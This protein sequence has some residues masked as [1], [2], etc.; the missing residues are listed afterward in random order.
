MKENWAH[1][2]VY[3]RQI[4][5]ARLAYWPPPIVTIL[6]DSKTAI[7]NGGGQNAKMAMEQG[8]WETPEAI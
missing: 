3:Q 6:S 2:R 7:F 8:H 4:H 1:E 5:R